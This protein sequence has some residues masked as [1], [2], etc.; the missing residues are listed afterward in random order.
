[1]LSDGAQIDDYMMISFVPLDIT[2]EESLDTV[3]YH[4]DHA[5]QYGEDLEPQD[6]PDFDGE[7][8]EEG[9][10]DDA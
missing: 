10:A 5:I 7:V 8:G 1:L 6:V 2:D 4:T 3:M 9:E